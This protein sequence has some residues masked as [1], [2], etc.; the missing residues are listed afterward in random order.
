M[1]KIK[2]NNGYQRDDIRVSQNKIGLADSNG[3]VS[4]EYTASE[5]FGADATNSTMF[6][7]AFPIYLRSLIQGINVSVFTYGATSSGK[8]HTM[9][10]KGA[11][12]GIVQLIAD[13]LFQILEEERYKNQSFTYTVKI[14]FMEI[15]DEEAYDLLQPQGGAGFNKNS[16]KYHEWEGAYVQG[17]NWVPVPNAN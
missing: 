8:S 6:N 3:R 17:I 1:V 12:L 9:Q 4:Q 15:V 16:L 2:P 14:R 5:I 10:G 11:E 13:N 7:Q